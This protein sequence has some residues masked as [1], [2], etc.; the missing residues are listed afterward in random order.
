LVSYFGLKICPVF[1]GFLLGVQMGCGE[2]LQ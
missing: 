1:A 2:V